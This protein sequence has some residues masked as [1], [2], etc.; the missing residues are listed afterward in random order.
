MPVIAGGLSD[1]GAAYAAIM[2]SESGKMVASKL[3]AAR[4][5]RVP[6]YE[7]YYHHDGLHYRHLWQEIGDTWTCP[8]CG[9]T[10][11]Q[12]MRWARRSPKSPNSFMGWVAPLH[13]HH[14][15]SVGYFERGQPRFPQT[16]ICDQCNASDGAAKRKL[17]LRSNF[18]FSPQEIALFVLATPHG[19][20]VINF[21]VAL[22]IYNGLA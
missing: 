2:R 20:H 16:T 14:D 6:T 8:G 17:K 10:K 12:I 1:A 19:K 4:G 18:S 3:D 13:R 9:R 21:D 5:I 7:D 22:S 15:H 11:Y